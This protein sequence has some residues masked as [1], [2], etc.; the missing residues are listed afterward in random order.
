[1]INPI[2]T[3]RSLLS[4]LPKKYATAEK[5]PTDSGSHSS[6]GRL[7]YLFVVDRLLPFSTVNNLIWGYLLSAISFSALL[8]FFQYPFHVWTARYRYKHRRS[9]YFQIQ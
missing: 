7:Q 2:G 9:K 5:S 8:V 4:F 1:L 6:I 3:L